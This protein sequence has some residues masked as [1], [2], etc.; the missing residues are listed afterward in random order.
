MSRA[1]RKPKTRSTLAGM[2]LKALN[3]SLAESVLRRQLVTGGRIAREY[4]KEIDLIQR[5]LEQK[6]GVPHG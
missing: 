4:L 1:A 6:F 3:A 5:V 2:S